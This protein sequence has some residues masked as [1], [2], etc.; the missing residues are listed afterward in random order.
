MC[1]CLRK[2]LHREKVNDSVWFW[3]LQWA[4]CPYIMYPGIVAVYCTYVHYCG[5]K[6]LQMVLHLFRRNYY[7]YMKLD[8]PIFRET[9]VYPYLGISPVLNQSITLLCV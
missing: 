7:S 2:Y 8:C 6:F 1:F 5:N 9:A 4:V 3:P